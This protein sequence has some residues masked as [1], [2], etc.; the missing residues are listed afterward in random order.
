MGRWLRRGC[1]RQ[2]QRLSVC[3]SRKRYPV[4]L[5]SS[6]PN[7]GL[8]YSRE[9]EHTTTVLFWTRGGDIER[10]AVYHGCLRRRLA[11][12]PRAGPGSGPMLPSF[13]TTCSNSRRLAR[14]NVHFLPLDRVHLSEKQLKYAV[15]QR[16]GP[17]TVSMQGYQRNMD[18]RRQNPGSNP[19]LVERRGVAAPSRRTT[20]AQRTTIPRPQATRQAASFYEEQPAE[21]GDSGDLDGFE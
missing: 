12:P 7:Q 6:F 4:E 20:L 13:K 14:K 1:S 21:Y 15:L 8:P 5:C 19:R 10:G 18:P 9:I 11:A 3:R 17:P 16:T 2:R